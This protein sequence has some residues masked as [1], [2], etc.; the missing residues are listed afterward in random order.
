MLIVLIAFSEGSELLG[1]FVVIVH[2]YFYYSIDSIMDYVTVS[3]CLKVT[4]K[5]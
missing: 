1:T 4:S 3:N 5:P 2:L